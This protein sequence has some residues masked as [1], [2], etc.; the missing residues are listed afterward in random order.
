MVGQPCTAC[1]DR[2]GFCDTSVHCSGSVRPR[3]DRDLQIIAVHYLRAAWLLTANYLDNVA[4]PPCFSRSRSADLLPPTLREIETRAAIRDIG[5]LQFS[6]RHD[7]NVSGM[8]DED[9]VNHRDLTACIETLYF[10]RNNTSL[11]TNRFIY[12][13]AHR[14][15]KGFAASAHMIAEGRVEWRQSIRF[16]PTERCNL[17]CSYCHETFVA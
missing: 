3:Q 9:A 16:N 2:L 4:A 10:S 1:E 7:P 5:S 8:I 15:S 12:I 6:Q 14:K 17:R 11:E 13:P